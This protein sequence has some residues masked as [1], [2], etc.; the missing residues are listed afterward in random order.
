VL[1]LLLVAGLVA[2]WLPSRRAL[3]V[4]PSEALRAD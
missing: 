1:A 3:A 4:R 2:S